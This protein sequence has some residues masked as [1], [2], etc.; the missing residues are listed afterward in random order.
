MTMN[1]NTGRRTVTTTNIATYATGTEAASYVWSEDEMIGTEYTL[2]L[3][4]RAHAEDDQ[5]ADGY[6]RP[7]EVFEFEF[8]GQRVIVF[9]YDGEAI[10]VITVEDEFIGRLHK[11]IRRQHPVTIGYTKQYDGDDTVRTVEPTSLRT[12]KSGD[13]TMGGRD[14]KTGEYRAFRVDHIADVT[15]HR[16]KFI[17]DEEYVGR[18]RAAHEAAKIRRIRQSAQ[19]VVVGPHGYT[20]TTAPETAGF[21][22]S[23]WSVIV[24]LDDRFAAV[25]ASGT[26][27]AA[28]EVIDTIPERVTTEEAFRA[29]AAGRARSTSYSPAQRSAWRML[30]KRWA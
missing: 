7:A 29:L 10:T 23:G 20:G 5:D 28:L 12:T 21:S 6:H 13:V 2:D 27:R 1:K 30:S 11:A 24:R 4:I 22:A 16:S 8:P 26:V 25:T 17:I 3:M 9:M 14:R 18:A 15:T 19:R